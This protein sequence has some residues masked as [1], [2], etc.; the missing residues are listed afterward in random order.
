MLFIVMASSLFFLAGRLN[1][2]SSN[3]KEPIYWIFFFIV[4]IY[5]VVT[6]FVMWKSYK[7]PSLKYRNL[8]IFLGVL[9]IAFLVYLYS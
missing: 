4:L 2:S 7:T 9:Y 8:S 6:S 1:F 5:I 3:D